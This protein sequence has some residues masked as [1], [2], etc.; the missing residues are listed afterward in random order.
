MFWVH[1][2]HTESYLFR[3]IVGCI[4]VK[5]WLQYVKLNTSKLFPSQL[6]PFFAQTSNPF[7]H[8]INCLPNSA[9]SAMDCMKN[10]PNVLKSTYWFYITLWCSVFGRPTNSPQCCFIF[11]L[12]I[13]VLCVC[14]CF[15]YFACTFHACWILLSVPFSRVKVYMLCPWC[16]SHWFTL[17][18]GDGNFAIVKQ[19]NLRNTPNE[20]AM[21]I[22]DK[23]K[24]KGK[25]HMVEHEIDIMKLCNHPNICKLIEEFET[26]DEI[27]LIMELVKVSTFSLTQEQWYITYH[28][29][30]IQ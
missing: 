16:E 11:I 8:S 14:L 23:K 7:C 12:A 29:A 2:L 21:K 28:C 9:D 27:Y 6:V 1:F 26:K 10:M 5:N 22:I 30:W 20:Y 17:I 15:Y 13:I 24:L 25:E 19:C 18:T 3:P 4:R